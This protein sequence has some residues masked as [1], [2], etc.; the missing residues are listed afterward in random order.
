MPKRAKEG[1]KKEKGRR[2]KES[3]NRTNKN[4][5]GK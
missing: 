4:T 3:T 2:T 1:I 5:K